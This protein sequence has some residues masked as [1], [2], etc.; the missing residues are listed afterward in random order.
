MQARLRFFAFVFFAS[1]PATVHADWP[2]YGGNA[3]H[4]GH[5]GVSGRPLTAILWQTPVDNHPGSFTHYGSP[6]ITAANTVIVPVTT[7]MG[8][9]FVVEGRRGDDGSLLW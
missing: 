4:T 8:A 3:Q 9:E 1:L 7:G 6:T 5:S 2:M